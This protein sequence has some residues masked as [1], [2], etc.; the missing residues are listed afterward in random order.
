MLHPN[1]ILTV[2]QWNSIYHFWN[3]P[4]LDKKIPVFKSGTK[5]TTKAENKIY[6][7]YSQGLMKYFRICLLLENVSMMCLSAEWIR[8]NVN[9]YFQGQGKRDKKNFYT[10]L[11]ISAFFVLTHSEAPLLLLTT[12]LKY[13]F[14]C[15]LSSLPMFNVKYVLF[16]SLRKISWVHLKW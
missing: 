8:T 16:P 11:V 14:V 2:A 9:I 12:W 3:H 1:G 4:G 10:H 13:M 6:Q 15:P 5:K 7:V